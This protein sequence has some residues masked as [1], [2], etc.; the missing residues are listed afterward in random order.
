MTT[1][2]RCNPQECAIAQLAGL[3]GFNINAPLAT[4]G[5]SAMPQRER[6]LCTATGASKV[7][8]ATYITHIHT[9]VCTCLLFRVHR[10]LS[11]LSSR[12]GS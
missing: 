4:C 10:A 2:E 8:P 6:T 9:P 3:P 5:T 1:A 12:A 11:K 7:Q